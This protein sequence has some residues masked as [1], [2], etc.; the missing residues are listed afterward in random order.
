VIEQVIKYCL[1]QKDD[2]LT[3]NAGCANPFVDSPKTNKFPFFGYLCFPP[4]TYLC[5]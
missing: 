1:I 3:G 2:Y 5:I 4:I